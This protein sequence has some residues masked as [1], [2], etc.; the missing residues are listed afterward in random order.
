MPT[1]ALK[2]CNNTSRRGKMFIII[3]TVIVFADQITK[4]LAYVFL[5]PH[6]TIP[7]INGFFYLT[8]VENRGAAFGIL[9]NKAG[10][11]AIITIII[12]IAAIYYIFRN[13]EISKSMRYSIALIIAGAIGNLIDRVRLGYVIDFFDFVVWPVFNIADSAVVIGSFILVFLL[14]FDKQK[15]EN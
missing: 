3:L 15:A 14:L 8:Y 1:I 2:C 13:P 4:Y 11:L 7:V 6:S 9:Q 5:Q 12:I 10:L